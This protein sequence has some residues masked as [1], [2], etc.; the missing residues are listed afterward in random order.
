MGT[1]FCRRTLIVQREW[2]SDENEFNTPVDGV[3]GDLLVQK[4]K[5]FTAG[6]HGHRRPTSLYAHKLRAGR[7]EFDRKEFLC[8][9]SL[10]ANI[11]AF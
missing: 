1:H 10:S 2:I 6:H 4:A 7:G 11:S 3:S 8:G 5:I 9:S